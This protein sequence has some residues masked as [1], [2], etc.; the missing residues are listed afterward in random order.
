MRKKVISILLTAAMAVTLFAGCGDEN[1]QTV[2]G[3]NLLVMQKL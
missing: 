2:R 1:R 3:I